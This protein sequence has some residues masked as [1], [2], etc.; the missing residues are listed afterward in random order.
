M[1]YLVISR[2]IGERIFIGGD[3]EIMVSDIGEGKVDIAV[4]APRNK[5]IVRCQ[6]HIEEQKEL[7]R[8]HRHEGNR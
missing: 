5:K 6:T 8:R 7:R 1:G 4:K 2:K 3:V